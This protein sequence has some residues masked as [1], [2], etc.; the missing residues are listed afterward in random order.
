MPEK[1][2]CHGHGLGGGRVEGRQV[3]RSAA[4]EKCDPDLRRGCGKAGSVLFCRVRTAVRQAAHRIFEHDDT[5]VDGLLTGHYAATAKRAEALPLMLIAQDTTAFVYG[6]SQIVGLAPLNQKTKSQ[7][8]YGHS[9]LALTPGGAPLGVWH[10]SLWGAPE[11]GK[12]SAEGRNR[13]RAD[14][15]SWKWFEGL[16]A[17]AERLPAGCEGLLIQDRERHLRFSGQGA[18]APAP[19]PPA[20]RARPPGGL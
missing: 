15:A 8:L 17:I 12:S 4:G 18:T 3:G 10:L 6:Q 19:T 20:G 1:E 16:E 14:K 5:S 7:G 13:A 2:L 11:E 9:A